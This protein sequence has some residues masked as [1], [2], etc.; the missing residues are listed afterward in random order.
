MNKEKDFFDTNKD[1]EYDKTTTLSV[2]ITE[3]TEKDVKIKAEKHEFI[4]SLIKSIAG[5][6]CIICGIVI[7]FRGDSTIE[8]PVIFF[9]TL[10]ISAAKLTTSIIFE[11]IGLIA[12]I[13]GKYRIKVKK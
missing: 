12:L 2:E 3:D 10:K 13:A 11:I 6:V 7:F 5:F 1:P 4:I 9:S 8:N